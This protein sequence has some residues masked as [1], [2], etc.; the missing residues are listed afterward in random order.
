MSTIPLS[1]RRLVGFGLCSALT[2]GQSAARA[3]LAQRTDAER[4]VRMR[5]SPDGKPV[6]WVYGGV[7]LVKVEGQAARPLVGVGGMSFTRAI[8]ESPGVYLWQ[9][10]EV[11]Y[12][13]DLATGKVLDTFLN[14]L[15]GKEVRP[16]NYRS[17][18]RMVY[19][20]S[21]VTT[22]DPVPPGTVFDGRIT[23]LADVGGVTAMTEDLYVSVPAQAA[24]EGK[25]ARPARHLASLA[26]FTAR[27]SDV[28][29]NS[30]RWIDCRLSYATMN[31]FA[32]WLQMS[33]VPGVQNM[34]LSGRK[35]RLF[36][37]GVIPDWLRG[38]I[39]SDHPQYFD[40]PTTW[41]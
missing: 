26:T 21:Q 33:D 40:E 11:G 2:W 15:N 25:P 16:A 23:R 19:R 24:Q 30:R 34:R 35:C 18:Q 4:F 38:R 41:R 32:P 7:L 6:M 14:P 10:D 27:A 37:A 36:E 12:Y 29:N 1:R 9:L 20:D 28:D 39:A 5:T 3:A 22:R 8:E 17:P 13:R 31:S